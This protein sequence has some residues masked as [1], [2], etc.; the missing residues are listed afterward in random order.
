METAVFYGIAFV[1]FAAASLATQSWRELGIL[2]VLTT[3][4]Y[5]P[6]KW[7]TAGTFLG[8]DMLTFPANG[9]FSLKPSA[10]LGI[11]ILSAAIVMILHRHFRIKAAE[12]EK[13]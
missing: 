4:L 12:S 7:L 11:A 3:I 9:G 5:W 2:L 6:A 8:G 1:A 10:P 13:P